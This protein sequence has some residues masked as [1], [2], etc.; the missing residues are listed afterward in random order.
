MDA[1]DVYRR[2]FHVREVV[3][4]HEAGCFTLLYPE[5]VPDFLSPEPQI[6]LLS[7]LAISAKGQKLSWRRDSVNVYAFFVEVPSA[8]IELEIQFQYLAPTDSNRFGWR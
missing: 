8:P 6:E 1:T 2:I 5:W 4:V 3:P 7:G